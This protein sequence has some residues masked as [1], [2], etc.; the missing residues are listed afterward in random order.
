MT[1]VRNTFILLIK[2]GLLKQPFYDYI[3]SFP[4]F[5][6]VF[7]Q[8]IRSTRLSLAFTTPN[9]MSVTLVKEQKETPLL[10]LDKLSKLVY[11]IE[12]RDMLIEFLAHLFSDSHCINRKVFYPF[13]LVFYPF[14]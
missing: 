1:N 9:S 11:I 5:L 7:S 13:D 14:G 2:F 8:L 12:C 10:L 3:I 6:K 4:L